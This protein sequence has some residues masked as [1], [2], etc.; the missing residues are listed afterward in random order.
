MEAL[1]KLSGRSGGLLEALWKLS[2]ALWG[3][4][5]GPL[6]AL[7]KLSGRSGGSLEALGALWKPSGGPLE[8]FWGPSEGSLEVLW[9]LSSV[10]SLQALLPIPGALPAHIFYAHFLGCISA[11]LKRRVYFSS[12]CIAS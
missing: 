5:G 11:V 9:G 4:S 6:G 10:A 3:P 2:A 8:A 12:A 1:W 7:W